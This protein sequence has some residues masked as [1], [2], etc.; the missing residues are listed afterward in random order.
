MS[1]P[2][3]TS[4]VV[5]SP[6]RGLRL[7]IR[8]NDNDND[9]D[10]DDDASRLTYSPLSSTGASPAGKS[11][12]TNTSLFSD[13]PPPPYASPSSR[14]VATARSNTSSKYSSLMQ[15]LDSELGSNGAM[16]FDDVSSMS[17]TSPP[18]KATSSSQQRSSSSH[19]FFASARHG[20]GTGSAAGSSRGTGADGSSSAVKSYGRSYVWDDWTNNDAHKS[21]VSNPTD[22]GDDEAGDNAT[23]FSLSATAKL[24]GKDDTKSPRSVSSKSLQHVVGEIKL[25]VDTMKS[26]LAQLHQGVREKQSQLTR[27]ATAKAQ[28]IQKFRALW[29]TKLAS[30]R[31]EQTAALKKTKD[32]VDR[33]DADVKQLKAKRDGLKHKRAALATSSENALL[34]LQDEL[35]RKTARTRRQWEVE[36]KAVFEKVF[37]SKQDSIKKA[38]AESFGPSLDRMVVEGKEAVRARADE[39]Y[40]RLDKIKREL[41]AELEEKVAQARENNREQMKLEQE[42][43]RR[44]AERKLEEALRK[45][46]EEMDGLKLK[47]SR[48]KKMA[49]ES[50]E[51]TRRNDAEVSL[52]GMREV[53]KAEAQQVMEV[54]VAQQRELGQVVQNHS[55]AMVQLKSALQAKENE[56]VIKLQKELEAEQGSQKERMRSS[57]MSRANA[58]SEK[59]IAKLREEIVAE[60]K[61]ARDK[62]ESELDDLRVS[63][64]H[65][66]DAVQVSENRLV[67]DDVEIA[68]I[69]RHLNLS[70]HSLYLGIAGLLS[71]ALL[72]AERSS[73]IVASWPTSMKSRKKRVRVLHKCARRSQACAWSWRLSKRRPRARSIAS[74]RSARSGARSR[75][76]KRRESC[77]TCELPRSPWRCKRWPLPT[78]GRMPG[79]CMR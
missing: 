15:F 20:G 64:Q 55:E 72:C 1:S 44:V 78:R 70:S 65:R 51:R 25:K 41:A 38:A 9:I 3:A 31:E 58:E 50:A 35:G 10:N 39:C 17:S 7:V 16:Q 12:S 46:T 34:L 28:R 5:S 63:A 27:L 14:S 26:Q 71:A 18:K 40:K 73:P 21:T 32:F 19:T 61:F 66:L 57:V 43:T 33:I 53:R 29:S 75:Q 6:S 48:E 76:G 22:Y 74:T 36:E 47:F 23:Y 69:Y 52:E 54:M 62:I 67:T 11:R 2:R 59:V 8:E 77:R 79:T 45:Q 56:F 49:E 68:P 37:Q 42:K 24:G 4:P 13:A 30:Q 60:R